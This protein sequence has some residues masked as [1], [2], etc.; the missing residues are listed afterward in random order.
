M[1][2]VQ[3]VLLDMLADFHKKGQ[4]S[5]KELGEGLLGAWPISPSQR[6][7][8][9]LRR[10]LRAE[11]HQRVEQI[12]TAAV[13]E[14][15]AKLAESRKELEQSKASEIELAVSR[16]IA[17]TKKKHWVGLGPACDVHVTYM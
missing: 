10:E 13:L 6:S 2:T 8:Q 12:K 4:S 14:C 11:M 15:E 7:L 5:A 17:E 3:L 9:E 1:G 16:A